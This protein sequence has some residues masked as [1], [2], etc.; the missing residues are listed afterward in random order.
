MNEGSFN[1]EEQTKI[2]T[3]E[4]SASIQAKFTLIIDGQSF[5]FTK[6]VRYRY[7]DPVKGEIY[8]PLNI[9]PAASVTTDP[10]VLV[11]RK[12]EKQQTNL[13]VRVYANRKFENYQARVSKRMKQSN[14]TTTDS[15]FNL[16]KGLWKDYIFRVDNSMMGQLEQ[17]NIQAFTELKKGDEVYNPY[18]SLT[19]IH[20][21]HIPDIYYFF[22]DNAK[23]L[24]I[25]LKT[26]GKRIGYVEG[27]GD[28]VPVALNQM[29]YEVIVLKEQDITAANLKQ[30]DA[31]ITGVRAYNVHSYLGERNN[32]LME[33][34]KEGG[35]LIVQYNTNSFAGPLASR[36][37]P[38]P[39]TISRSRVTDEKAKVNFL[40]KDHPVL[41]YPNKITGKDFEGWIQ[42]RGLY[43]GEKA[44][45]HY[46]MPLSMADPGE[47]QHNGSLLITDYGKGT[48]VY[49]GLVFFRELPAGV[50]GAYRLMANIIALSKKKAF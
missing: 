47:S 13:L 6:P 17:D 35:N 43:F 26:V 10:G 12:G 24:N 45:P 14:S 32:E 23:A 15:S 5:H 9:V 20:Y 33:Y 19:G 30:F 16:P 40:I 31:V 27:A 7:S 4:N 22:Q 37:G 21:D 49:T 11:F 18:L 50:P 8:Q 39:F 3:P 38:Y 46:Q 25:D 29:G 44:D 2:G 42:E 41:Y 36:I 28:K 1:V 48:F 34:V